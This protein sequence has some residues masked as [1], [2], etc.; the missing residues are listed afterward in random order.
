MLLEIKTRAENSKG[1]LELLEKLPHYYLQCQLQLACT[2]GKFCILLSYHPETD[3]GNFFLIQRNDSVLNVIQDVCNC[4]LEK[5]RLLEWNHHENNELKNL[6]K[7]LIGKIIDFENLKPLRNYV[8]RKAKT[9]HSV[10]FVDNI[11]F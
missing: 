4:I 2:D 11:D 3:T 8:R 9:N 7:Q 10:I 1:P 6:G 5:K